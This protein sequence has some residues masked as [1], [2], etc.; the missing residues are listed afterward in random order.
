MIWNKNIIIIKPERPEKI[1]M[2][3]VF[4]FLIIWATFFI[5][6]C[7]STAI[8]KENANEASLLLINNIRNHDLGMSGNND[9]Y[10]SSGNEIFDTDI[11]L[12]FK[13][14]NDILI[15]FGEP[16]SRNIM[17]YS[18]PGIGILKLLDA[19]FQNKIR[20]CEI[21]KMQWSWSNLHYNRVILFYKQDTN[22]VSITNLTFTD[23]SML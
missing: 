4:Y 19:P 5:S 3:I 8:N 22:W 6:A 7:N 9:N 21:L 16:N 2:K 18:K 14:I 11:S 12:N 13:S 1:N 10:T 17:N 15:L 20:E 23:G